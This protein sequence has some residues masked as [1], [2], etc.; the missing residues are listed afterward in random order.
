LVQ[1]NAAGA[2]AFEATVRVWSGGDRCERWKHKNRGIRL[3]TAFFNSA[4]VLFRWS[5]ARNNYGPNPLTRA[6]NRLM[7]QHYVHMARSPGATPSTV[8]A[9]AGITTPVAAPSPLQGSN[10]S[11]RDASKLY[12]PSSSSC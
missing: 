2:K 4:K 12:R 8:M 1:L 5:V 6:R 9:P 11:T 7:H 3:F 10:V